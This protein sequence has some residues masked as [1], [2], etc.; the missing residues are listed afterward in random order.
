MLQIELLSLQGEPFN[1][2]IVAKR[3][4]KYTSQAVYSRSLCVPKKQK[5]ITDYNHQNTGL[6]NK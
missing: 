2:I 4:N 5:G 3:I 6:N 1:K